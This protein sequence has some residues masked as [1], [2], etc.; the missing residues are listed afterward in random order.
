MGAAEKIPFELLALDA[1]EVGAL[2]GVER[3]YV[4]ERLAPRPGF[5]APISCPGAH[6]RWQAG[7]VLEW[8]ELNRASRPARR[9]KSGSS[10]KEN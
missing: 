2:F 6:K 10:A 3:R 7:E 8:R 9:R 5:P 1:T 4:L